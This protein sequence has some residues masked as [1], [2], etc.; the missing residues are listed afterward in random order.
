[1]EAAL[2]KQLTDAHEEID[3][4]PDYPDH[5]NETDMDLFNN[6]QGR[7][8]ATHYGSFISKLVKNAFDNGELRY[9]NNLV[10]IML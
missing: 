8:L 1:M 9:L 6:A 10:F 2:T 4:D 7:E 5:Y 3:Y